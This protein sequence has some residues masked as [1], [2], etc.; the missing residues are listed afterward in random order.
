[1]SDRTL[2]LQMVNANTHIGN[3][4]LVRSDGITT[5]SF[6][7]GDIVFADFNALLSPEEFHEGQ[8]NERIPEGR[9]ILGTYVPLPLTEYV[10]ATSFELFDREKT[11]PEELRIRRRFR[12]LDNNEWY[13]LNRGPLPKHDRVPNKFELAVIRIIE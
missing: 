10:V 7:P 2:H 12:W 11:L 9:N 8:V 1:M 3:F 4:F 6:F 13:K 5:F